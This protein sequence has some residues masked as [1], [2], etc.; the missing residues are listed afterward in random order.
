M[1]EVEN[2]KQAGSRG[3]GM[4]VLIGQRT[5]SSYTSDLSRDGVQS[6]VHAAVDLAEITTEDP[7]AGLPEPAEF[8]PLSGDLRLFDRD[9]PYGDRV[10]NRSGQ[11]RRR[12]RALRRPADPEF[13][14]C[15]LRFEYGRAL[16][17]QFERFRR[18]IPHV[19][20]WTE[21]GSCGSS[22][23]GNMERD[24]WYTTSRYAAGLEGAEEVGRIAAARALRRLNAAQNRHP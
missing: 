6:M 2:L 22:S 11:A 17:R 9:R 15:V 1:R 20:L 24:Y 8:G 13:R 4:R 18:R 10:Q 19:E 16:L 12:S 23:N 21:R 7:H 5:G 3:A 14:R